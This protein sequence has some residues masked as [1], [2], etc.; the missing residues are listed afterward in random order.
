MHTKN[1]T[2][3]FETEM[4]VGLKP[5]RSCLLMIYIFKNTKQH[6]KTLQYPSGGIKWILCEWIW[7]AC[8]KTTSC[9]L[10]WTLNYNCN[11]TVSLI[12]LKAKFIQQISWLCW[13][14]NIYTHF[15]SFV[16]SKGN[17]YKQVLQMTIKWQ[18][19]TAE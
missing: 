10:R 15:S 7:K 14:R 2:F 18:K 12:S 6:P 16:L 13:C 11:H 9:D 19:F 17:F 8:V 5:L 1:S 4:L 3:Y